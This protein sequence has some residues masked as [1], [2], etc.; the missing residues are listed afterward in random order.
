MKANE[1][2]A[3]HNANNPESYFFSRE[4]LNFFGEK[5]SEMHV[6]K[7]TQTINGPDGIEH[8]C[9]IL[10]SIQHN[11]PV[12]EIKRRIYHYIDINTFEIIKSEK[13]D[14]LKYIPLH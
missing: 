7:N 11:Y 13:V 5:K 9:Y 3:L 10:T 8:E 4:T 12:K 1:L 14:T 2:I 6:Y